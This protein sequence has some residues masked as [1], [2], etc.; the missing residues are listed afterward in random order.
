MSN[1]SPDFQNQDTWKSAF[2]EFWARSGIEEPQSLL[3]H[4][5]GFIT[6]N[7]PVHIYWMKVHESYDEMKLTYR[8]IDDLI[9][10]RTLPI[11]TRQTLAEAYFDGI[12]LCYERDQAT[13]IGD[14]ANVFVYADKIGLD[15]PEVQANIIANYYAYI[16][17]QKRAADRREKGESGEDIAHSNFDLTAHIVDL[18]KNPSLEFF[19]QQDLYRY[20]LETT[21]EEAGPVR[22]KVAQIL[23]YPIFTH[24]SN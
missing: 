21:R 4:D 3:T 22:R 16:E 18:K 10:D 11:E 17:Y 15:R 1:L 8:A 20:A 23:N 7:I 24:A 13:S 2:A 5:L 14:T 12:R 6:D 19:S 9:S